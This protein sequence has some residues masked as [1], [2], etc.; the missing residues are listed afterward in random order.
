MLHTAAVLQMKQDSALRMKDK[1]DFVWRCE[2]GQ[3]YFRR[4]ETL[5][6]ASEPPCVFDGEFT[7]E[8]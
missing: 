8:P 1:H 6:T 2:D 4:D 5:W 3:F 7:V